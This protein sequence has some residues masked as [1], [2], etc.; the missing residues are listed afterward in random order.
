MYPRE[1]FDVFWRAELRDEV[2]VAMPFDSS[3]NERWTSIIRPAVQE[4]GL[5][6]RRVDAT[7]ISGNI[8]T[9]IMDGIAH[10]QL[11]L[12]DITSTQV[13]DSGRRSPNA[14][15]LYEIGL[16]HA[17]RQASEVL[18]IRADS[19]RLLF[20]ISNIR[21]HHYDPASIADSKKALSRLILDCLAE[22]DLTKSLKVEDALERLDGG[23]RALIAQFR[24]EGTFPVIVERK[25]EG[26]G[27]EYVSEETRANYRKLVADTWKSWLQ[28]NSAVAA[29]LLDLRIIK[30]G[31][32]QQDQLPF[33]YCWTAFG[34]NVL[35]RLDEVEKRLE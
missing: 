8:I 32:S 24:G 25:W 26:P 21:V 33:Q 18:L 17:L 14:N 12:G 7:A 9:E 2:F 29:R 27:D 4:A 28:K 10:A 6:P 20:D 23:C 22:I 3:S 1:Y 34:K 5:K 15:V 11:V 13:S 16:A 19:V 35:R 30:C 31:P